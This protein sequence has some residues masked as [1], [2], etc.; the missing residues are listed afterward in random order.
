MTDKIL[1]DVTKDPKRQ[2]KVKKP[3]ETYMKRLK[4]DILMDT[5]FSS[6]SSTY[7]SA[8]STSS[9][10]PSTPSSI[11]NSTARSSDTYL[12]GIRMVAVLAIDTCVLFAYNKKILS[13]CK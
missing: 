13:G 9:S 5:Q 7:N 10:T 11:D 2:E 8:P 3:Q 4:E 12:Y 1:K 6:S